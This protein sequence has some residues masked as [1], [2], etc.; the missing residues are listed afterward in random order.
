[1]SKRALV[2]ALV[3]GAGCQAINDYL[4]DGGMAGGSGGAGGI[5]GGAGGGG[6]VGGGGGFSG[7]GG[8]GC[9]R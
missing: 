8:I 7:G 6:G 5:A 4:P 1:M 3:A 9:P 2:I